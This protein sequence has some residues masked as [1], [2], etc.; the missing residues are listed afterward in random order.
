[1]CALQ[2]DEREEW[3]CEYATWDLTDHTP[4]TAACKFDGDAESE[5]MDVDNEVDKAAEDEEDEEDDAQA[6]QEDEEGENGGQAEADSEDGD[7][8]GSDH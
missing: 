6:E 2:E 1:M 5:Q 7:E 3:L 8:S 4:F